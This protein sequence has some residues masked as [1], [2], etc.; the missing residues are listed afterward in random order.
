MG[1]KEWK[2]GGGAVG[3]GKLIG[4][5]FTKY[6]ILRQIIVHLIRTGVF[7]LEL[8]EGK[9]R[10]LHTNYTVLYLWAREISTN[11]FANNRILLLG[12]NESI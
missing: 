1:A 3:V 2:G 11:T 7:Q 9:H 12:I 4:G 5:L 6:K 8:I 10:V